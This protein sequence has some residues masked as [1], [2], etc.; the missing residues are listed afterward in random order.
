M[1]QFFENIARFRK[2]VRR[3][4]ESIK[5]YWQEKYPSS[6]GEKRFDRKIEPPDW[7]LTPQPIRNIYRKPNQNY[8][9]VLLFGR[10][11]PILRDNNGRFDWHTDPV[12]SIK[13]EKLATQKISIRGDDR[14]G[15]VKYVWEPSRFYHLFELCHQGGEAAEAI[16]HHVNTWIDSNPWKIGVH[17]DNALESSLRAISFTYADGCLF[18]RMES[19]WI[20]IREKVLSAIWWHG[21]F[22]EENL[23]KGGYNHLVGD[24]AGLFI[25]GE[26]YP[27]LPRSWYWRELGL[28]ILINEIERQILPDGSHVEQAPAYA[29]FVA[30]FFLLCGIVAGGHDSQKGYILLRAA[31][32]LLE[33]LM[34]QSTPTADLAGYG[35]DD[36]GMVLWFCEPA[37]RLPISLAIA[38]AVLKRKD[39]KFAAELAGGRSVVRKMIERVCGPAGLK[40]FDELEACRPDATRTK[41]TE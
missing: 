1:A 23:S 12:H 17:W 2:N 7:V 28:N 20:E 22:I 8:D 16:A 5:L 27:E 29:R 41:K 19:S 31:E 11:Y 4:I 3:H 15:D 13:W 26:S 24:A 25:I 38:A 40:T 14:P 34:L 30:D 35:D 9:K 33:A 6:I 10:Q 39:F 32:R 36:G 37:K 21:K 18:R